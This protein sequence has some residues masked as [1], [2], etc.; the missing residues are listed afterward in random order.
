[1]KMKNYDARIVFI[2]GTIASEIELPADLDEESIPIALAEII[3]DTMK[4]YG[5][6]AYFPKPEEFFWELEE[7]EESEEVA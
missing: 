5:V 6:E 2:C 1:M 7:W 3:D 4:N